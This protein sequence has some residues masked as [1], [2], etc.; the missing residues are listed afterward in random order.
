[1]TLDE[2]G[3]NEF[4][5]GILGAAAALAGLVIV[6]ASVNIS[7]IVKERSL[8]ARLGA[9]IAT[10][11]LAITASALAL[12]PG[13][14]LVWYGIAVLVAAVLCSSFPIHAARVLIADRDP[15][16]RYKGVRSAVNFLP[17]IVY[18]V[19][20]ALLI[21][22][23]PAGLIVVAIGAIVAIPVALMI[24]WVVLVEVLR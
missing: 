7:E 15:L 1:M 24:S 19:G 20:A 12:F 23:I 10:L 17:A 8:T 13:I 22:G 5:L 6:A 11:V 2:M 21:A 4:N 9:G 14:T 18:V 3:W 16:S